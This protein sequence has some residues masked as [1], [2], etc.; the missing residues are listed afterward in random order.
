MDPST[1]RIVPYELSLPSGHGTL[2]VLLHRRPLLHLL[3]GTA[4]LLFG[5]RLAAS[6]V[7]GRE[8]KQRLRLRVQLLWR[9]EQCSSKCTKHFNSVWRTRTL[10]DTSGVEMA[11]VAG[12]GPGPSPRSP[13]PARPPPPPKQC[14]G[15]QNSRLHWSASRQNNVWDT[16]SC[17]KQC[18]GH[19]NSRIHHFLPPSMAP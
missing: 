18:L 3:P 14:L 12:R 6:P 5:L 7:G 19:P 9:L 1:F 16:K 15:H 2:R 11:R 8:E 10:G 13:R 4:L 17:M